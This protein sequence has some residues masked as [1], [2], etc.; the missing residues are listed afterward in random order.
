M[1]FTHALRLSLAAKGGAKENPAAQRPGSAASTPRHAAPGSH[2]LGAL[3]VAAPPGGAAPAAKAKPQPMFMRLLKVRAALGK[4]STVA[5]EDDDYFNASGGI[6][7][8]HPAP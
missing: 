2:P 6:R 4:T 8:H 7:A 1:A 3:Q 5:N